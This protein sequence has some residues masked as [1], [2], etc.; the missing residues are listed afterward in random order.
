MPS[1][2]NPLC[3]EPGP[4]DAR[5]GAC[6]WRFSGGRG[7]AVDRCRRH[8]G[9]RVDP[10]WPACAAFEASLDCQA[11]GACCREAYHAVEVSRRDPFVRAHPERVVAADGRLQV[12]RAGPRCACL[13]G[14]GPYACVVYDDRPRTCRDFT[15]G[16]ANC[17]EARR[18]VGLTR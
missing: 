1:A 12:R 13:V 15:R 7:R 16:S 6:A 9:A 11:C 17:V 4:P 18:R 14:D 3:D 2:D 8:D 10:A 5:C